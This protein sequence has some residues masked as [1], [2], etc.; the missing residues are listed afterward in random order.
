VLQL[1]GE[2]GQVFKRDSLGVPDSLLFRA[3]GDDS[4][5][6]YGYRTLGP[7]RDGAVV[8]GPV[9]ATASAE[10]MWPLS[11]RLR[12]WYGA[13][14]VDM[15]NAANTWRGFDLARGYGAG[16]RWR[17]PIGPLKADVAYGEATGKVRVHLSVGV[18]F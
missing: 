7:V 3:G 9:M 18:S 4:V 12:D 5:R 10:L 6:G 2:A 1:R 17:S 14:F 13:V 15:G 11:D 8:G 16:V